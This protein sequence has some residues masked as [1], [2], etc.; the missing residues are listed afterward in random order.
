MVFGSHDPN[1]TWIVSL[2]LPALNAALSGVG[3]VC[4]L[5]FLYLRN[6]PCQSDS[7][8]IPH[9]ARNVCV[10]MARDELLLVPR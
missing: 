7:L 1:D 6:S 4:I 3:N 9:G 2:A 8:F 5:L 10:Q